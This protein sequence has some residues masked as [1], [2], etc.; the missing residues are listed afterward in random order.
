[1][2]SSLRSALVDFDVSAWSFID[3][4]E[5]ILNAI[6]Y[7]KFSNPTA[8]QEKALP[9]ALEGR[10]IIGAAETVRQR[11]FSLRTV[12]LHF[13]NVHLNRVPVKLWRSQYP[14]CSILSRTLTNR[15]V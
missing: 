13:L 5:P 15:L 6:R 11:R 2:R 14:S 12:S 10:D 4:A 7:F 1:M 8:I 3:L 9:L